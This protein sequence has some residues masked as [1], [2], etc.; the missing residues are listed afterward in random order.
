M[1][2][3]ELIKEKLFIS[4]LLLLKECLTDKEILDYCNSFLPYSVGI[5]IEAHVKS[6]YL[7]YLEGINFYCLHKYNHSSE[8]TFRIP[9][10][11]KGLLCLELY[12]SYLKKYQ[13]NTDSG[14][15]Y[16]IDCTNNYSAINSK[17]K[18]ERDFVLSELDK[19]ETYDTVNKREVV[20]DSKFNWVNMRRHFNTA[21]FRIG[22]LT[23]EFPLL[24]N[25]IMSLTHIVKTIRQKYDLEYEIKYDNDISIDYILKQIDTNDRHYLSLIDLK[26][27]EIL[28][29][30]KKVKEERGTLISELPNKKFLDNK[31][32]KFY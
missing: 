25:R 31:V 17:M 12:S 28:N 11:Y 7:N 4:P 24:L 10:G 27:Q 15:H 16:H 8:Q 23:C 20:S 19:W 6:E 1:V 22:E 32:L 5:E 18:L 14:N 30:R 13:T 21:E 26:K 29:K 9:E 3:Y 2:D